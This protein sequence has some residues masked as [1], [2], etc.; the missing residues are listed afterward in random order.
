MN[1]LKN[2]LLSLGMVCSAGT[3]AGAPPQPEPD[4]AHP[5]DVLKE[6]YA[7]L[8]TTEGDASAGPQRVRAVLEICH[9]ATSI[10][11][12]SAFSLVDMCAGLAASE[13]AVPAKAMMQLA[14][15]KL[16][17][18]IYDS[19]F[20]VYNRLQT[21]DEPVPADIREWNGR[22]FK[23]AIARTAREAMATA[24]SQPA[25]LDAYAAAVEADSLTLVYFPAVADFVACDVV[26]LLQS[27]DFD[28]EADG[29]VARMR[30][31]AAPG[32]APYYYWAVEALDHNAKK[33][34]EFYAAHEADEYA[35]MALERL[36]MCPSRVSTYDA[37]DY[38]YE[39]DDEDEEETDD[40]TDNEFLAGLVEKSLERFPGYWNN[41]RL[42]NELA[43]LRRPSV[44]VSAPALI[45][46]GKP[47]KICVDARNAAKAEARLYKLDSKAS[48]EARRVK[49]SAMKALQTFSFDAEREWF[50]SFNAEAVVQN[51][52]WYSL[53]PVVD[54]EM[55]DKASAYHYDII[56]ATPVVP[57]AM[58]GTDEQI[59]AM[60]DF[61]TG[62]PVQGVRV[63][64]SRQ[65][66]ADVPAGV[67]DKYGLAR[68]KLKGR[69]P[70]RVSA[71]TP[72]GV[73]VDFGRGL[74]VSNPWKSDSDN[75]V[76]Y[77][78]SVMPA[79]PIY[80]PGDTLQ[81]AVVIDRSTDRNRTREAATDV[82]AEVVLHDAN[83]QAV[84]TA[85]VT[86]DRYGRAYGSF[87]LPKDLL[88]GNFTLEVIAGGKLRNVS[89]VMVSDYRMPTFEVAGVEVVRDAPSRGDVTLRGRAVTYS[90]MPVADAQVSAEINGTY[91]WRWWQP[92]TY[93]G[94]V[95]ARTD[96][97][98]GFA[99]VVAD[100]L[101]S[102]CN[103]HD[104]VANIVVTSPSAEVASAR[105]VFTN[106]RPYAIRF[107]DGRFIKS[108]TRTILPIEVYD[109]QGAKA[110]ITLK[111]TLRG[112][113]DEKTVASG[114]CSSLNP[115]ADL[116][117]VRGGYYQLV[118]EPADK[119]LADRVVS[120]S[121]ILYNVELNSLPADLPLLVD[122]TN[123]KT[124]AAGRAAFQYGVGADNTWLYAV[125]CAGDKIV[126]MEV[127]KR[128]KGFR[129]LSLDLP[130]DADCGRLSMFTVRDGRV[131][132]YDV[133]ITRPSDRKLTISGESFRDR[134]VPG[135]A[136][137]WRLRVSGADG[138]DA[139]AAM[140]ATMYN[141]ALDA[142][143]QLSWPSSFGL[144]RISPTM[145]V[146]TLTNPLHWAN[147]DATIRNL[148][149]RSLDTPEFRFGLMGYRDVVYSY[150]LVAPTMKKSSMR[151]RGTMAIND[152][153]KAEAVEEE[154]ADTGA[155]S[156][157]EQIVVSYGYHRAD[158]NKEQ[159]SYR[160][161]EVPQAFWMPALATDE[162]GNIDMA[163]TVPDANTTWRMQALAWTDDMRAGTMVRDIVANKPVMVQP[164]LPRFLREGDKARVLATVYNNGAD[165]DMLHTVVELFDAATLDV[166][167]TVESD[168]Y[169]APRSSAKVGIDID[170]PYTATA[171]GYRVRSSNG[172][173]ADGEQALIP[174][175]SAQC[176]VV[177]S[178]PF[179]LNPGDKE[180]KLKVPSDRR[181]TYTLQYCQNPS[182]SIVKALP[183]LVDYEPTTVF[184]AARSLF[185][186]CTARGIVERTPAVAEAVARW[187]GADITSRLS[188]NEA[189]KTVALQATPWVRAA[190][191]DSERM[192]R[193][194][195]LL[196]PE[197][198]NADIAKATGVL[199][200]LADNNGGFRWG[201][202][203]DEPSLWA[204][205]Q[206]LHTL[207][208]LRMAG[209][210]PDD[211]RIMPMMRKAL[212]YMDKEYGR[213]NKKVTPD[214]GYAV[215]RSQWKDV[216]PSSF[217]RKVV[218]A[219]L[220]DCTAKWKDA[221]TARKADMA[222][223]LDI[224]GRT[225]VAREIIGSISQ[226]A[227]STA[228][229][230]VSFPSVSSI[231][232][233]APLLISFGR[234]DATSPLIDGMRQ[235]LVVREQATVGMGA[236]DASQLISA[237]L[238]SGTPWHTDNAPATVTLDGRAVDL[239][240]ACSY[241]GEA[242]VA[243]GSNAAGR[244][245][246]V[247]PAASVPSYGAL[248]SSYR[249]L[250]S[251]IEAVSCEAVS[252]E[253]RL[254]AVDADGTSVYADSV[255]LGARVRVIL[256]LH[257]QRDMQYVSIVDERA[258]ALEPLVQTPGFEIS[259]GARFYRESGD[260]ATRLFIDWLPKGTYQISYDCIANNAGTYAGGIAT[261]QSALAPALT[262]HSSGSVLTVR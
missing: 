125:L 27:A 124:N 48:M 123:V 8:K 228:S 211:V 144:S 162:D 56:I 242:T 42:R 178:K 253:K 76:G 101:L 213:V 34:Y 82:E 110:D 183:G 196:D 188:Q 208:L 148:T 127:Q 136:E 145:T 248:I 250:P 70:Y 61:T 222:I 28:K 201:K 94:T 68:F 236:A 257:V 241:G 249:A 180:F 234:V 30:D 6:A 190:Q 65:D 176:D 155:G 198:C 73:R 81:W 69:M 36:L 54:G 122:V 57:V 35:R 203:S 128:D 47:F 134:L 79:R 53:R 193:L 207:G 111:W 251:E 252:I 2:M 59:V 182:W 89:S 49:F 216:A 240:E 41:N 119:E 149:T 115:V 218:D 165:A 102:A 230:G 255:E 129:H 260:E 15:S 109:A 93:V 80:H 169:V 67:T 141:H 12:D 219:T 170:A 171:I 29:I 113:I 72:S 63:L 86:T 226:F 157:D 83:Y 168:N 194:A 23:A 202:W 58:T 20:Y 254:V 227:V 96:A 204:T 71:I 197:R 225:A 135:A 44:S 118:V 60:A 244:T 247:K 95:D 214:M 131:T 239:G 16:L 62:A 130:A 5:R 112:Y 90:G 78:A 114:T 195:L 14:E 186:A 174:I 55:D 152:M 139:D 159:F 209:Y 224:Y 32:S 212:S 21:P 229:Q 191:S 9:A 138:K 160:D 87:A 184:G 163:F 103:L 199:E 26:S 223:L 10:D 192:A 210:L 19:K 185:A 140:T 217:G 205:E 146:N 137:N 126:E 98:G 13:E 46:P 181:G 147:I 172:V 45:C 232:S 167:A 24:L 85:R 206:V 120:S 187:N 117:R 256:T 104:F 108:L 11:P 237:F 107:T 38:L 97:A 4:F 43:R 259:A 51:A 37:E 258:A 261:L 39:D 154:M 233:Y 153:A 143:A 200:G 132:R 99:L 22:Q 161:A 179:Y 246:R 64:T 100:S 262:A 92:S 50:K 3:A 220:A 31:A 33:L 173:F 151:V 17:R 1:A 158:Y 88:T 221:S 133:E 238:N 106:G 116:D 18:N 243:L 91:R 150:G 166:L 121:Y 75:G 84:D 235:W 231:E 105:K 156:L 175:A 25:P 77:N 189:L 177:E 74:T 142:L 245:L 52:G 215:V 164:N 40:Y 7:V 66:K